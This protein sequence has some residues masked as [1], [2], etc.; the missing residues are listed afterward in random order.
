MQGFAIWVTTNCNM[1]CTYCYEGNNKENL[2]ISEKT[3]EDTILFIDNYMSLNH[4]EDMIIDFHGGE[5]LLQF[6]AIRYAVIE[7]KKKFN[8]RVKFGITTNGTIFSRQI[9]DFLCDNFYYSLSISLDGNKETHNLNRKLK[10]GEGSYELVINNAKEF[11]KKRND[12]RIRMTVNSKTVTGLYHS[13][14]DLIEQGFRIIAPCIDYF[15]INWN[16]T[17]MRILEEQLILLKNELNKKNDLVQVGLLNDYKNTSIGICQGG[18]N[19]YHINPKGEIFPCAFVM[20]NHKYFL[21]DIYNGL[22]DMEVIKIQAINEVQNNVCK[23]CTHIAGCIS[24]RCKL[25]NKIISND[26]HTPAAT[27]CT[28]ENIKYK[29]SQI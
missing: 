4:D 28:M 11:L 27:V 14:M 19:S 8:D 26:Y 20:G 24:S 7:L 16:K 5:P 6:E 3:M 1:N 15:D 2:N 25:L 17:N 21:G 22:K 13:V 12:V 23:G 18:K 10:N 29:V 9:L